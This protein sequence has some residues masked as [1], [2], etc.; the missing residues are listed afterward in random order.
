MRR[1]AAIVSAKC[2]SASGAARKPLV[3]TR[4]PSSSIRG[5]AEAYNNLGYLHARQ[6]RLTD[7]EVL[8]RKA[9]ELDSGYAE[10]HTNLGN[11]LKDLRRARRGNRLLSARDRAAP[12][13][14]GAAQQP[15]V[16][17]ALSSRLLARRSRCASIAH[18]PSGTWRRSGDS[19]PP[20]ERRRA[21][22]PIAHRLRVARLS[23]ASGGALRSAAAPRARPT[24]VRG[25]CIL[26]RDA[27]G[28]GHGPGPRA[29]GSM[30]RRRDALGR[31]ARRRRPRGRDRHPRGPRCAFGPT[32]GCSRSRASRRPCRSRISPIA[33]RRASMRSTIA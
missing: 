10:P 3:A 16:L 24:A 1:F 28:R 30:A 5:Y 20:R 17:A 6:D 25:L 7:A 15:S 19:P 9:I 29:R 14:V 13:F 12:G 26:R 11:L 32:T 4:R 33:A 23:R 27:S 18:G 8:Y 21:G 2:S 31:A 22:T